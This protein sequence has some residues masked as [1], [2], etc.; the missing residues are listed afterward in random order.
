M[1]GLY[2]Y[3]VQR[4]CVSRKKK[5][6]EYY[7]PET[8]LTYLRIH[9]IGWSGQTRSKITFGWL[10]ITHNLKQRAKSKFYFTVSAI[11]LCQSQAAANFKW[12]RNLR[13]A[14]NSCYSAPFFTYLL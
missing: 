2:C 9:G 7:I 5:V 3:P 4:A 12:D 6:Y 1:N 14:A 13:F 11:T 10:C 8:L